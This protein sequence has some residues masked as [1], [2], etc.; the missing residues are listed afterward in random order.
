MSTDEHRQQR[1]GDANV[2]GIRL[3][4]REIQQDYLADRTA[5]VAAERKSVEIGTTSVVIFRIWKE[6][7]ALPTTVFQEIG[8]YLGAHSIP[9]HNGGS[10]N[11][12]TN[13]RGELVLSI[14]LGHFFQMEK[15]SDATDGQ[16]NATRGRVL[17]CGRDGHRFAFPVTEVHGVHK[18]LP[19][20]LRQV[21]ATLAR[22]GAGSFVLGV[23]PWGDKT[24]A[25]LDDQLLFYA[26]EKGL[27]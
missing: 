19:A 5:H 11:G 4:D 14:S 13:I 25:C 16:A 12:L 8:E 18:Y 2:V 9:H 27:L 1:D 26:L 10:L 20:N 17:I 24:V 21:P 15:P 22:A 3:L 6:W 23:L 7:F